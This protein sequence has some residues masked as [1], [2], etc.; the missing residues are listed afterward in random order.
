MTLSRRARSTYENR[1]EPDLPEDADGPA[2][3]EA[4]IG[5]QKYAEF[6]YRAGYRS[7]RYRCEKAAKR[8]GLTGVALFKHC[9]ERLSRSG[10][11]RFELVETDFARG[12]AD[13]R[14]TPS[15]FVLAQAQSCAATKVCYLLSGWLDGVM[16]GVG[17]P[18]QGVDGAP[19]KT[20]CCETQ[21]AADG[22]SHCVFAV[23][24]GPSVAQAPRTE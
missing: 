8:H 3:L 19:L 22:H 13:I 9:L 15:T 17:E 24:P 11:G 16:R 23:R 4:S 10:W 5:R 14:L 1:P 2:A 7:A 12:H 6:V 18:Q 20:L 21:C